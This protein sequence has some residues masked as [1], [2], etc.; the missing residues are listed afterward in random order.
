MRHLRALLAPE[1]AFT[2]ADLGRIPVPT[3]LIAGEA[4]RFASLDWPWMPDQMGSLDQIL[5]MRRSIPRSELLILNHAGL[6]GDAGDAVQHTRADLVGPVMLEFLGR[7][8]RP[9]PEAGG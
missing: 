9:A 5:A 2:E 7:H 3:L 8:A 6:A 1:P 4:D